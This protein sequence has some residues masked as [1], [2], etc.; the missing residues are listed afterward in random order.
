MLKKVVV[1]L[2]AYWEWCFSNYFLKR[3]FFEH[4]RYVKNFCIG[5]STKDI[6]EILKSE[7]NFFKKEKYGK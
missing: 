2:G 3:T 4:Y 7:K 1:L 5:L 6:I